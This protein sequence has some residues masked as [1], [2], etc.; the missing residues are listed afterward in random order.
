MPDDRALR[1]A[2]VLVDGVYNT[3]LVAPWDI[4]EHTRYHTA[5][6]PGIEVFSVAA[7]ADPVTTAEGLRILPDHTFET[8]PPVDI[9]VVPSTRES[10]GQDLENSELINWVRKTGEEASFVMS[11][12]WGAFVLAEAGLLDGRACTTYPSDYELFSRQFPELDL[13]VNVSYVHD[14]KTL[15]SEGGA[16]SFAAAMYLVDFLYGEEVASKIGRG[17]LIP[18]PASDKPPGAAITDPTHALDI[19]ALGGR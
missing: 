9:L 14:G 7:T 18:W 1:A 6:A 4:F 13:R 5:P 16:P 3:E 10:R 19:A 17:L 11:L 8:A 2:F 12:C 15:T